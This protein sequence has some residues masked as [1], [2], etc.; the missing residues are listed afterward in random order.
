MSEQAAAAPSRPATWYQLDSEA[1]R[2]TAAERAVRGE[3]ARRRCRGIVMR[4][5]TRRRTGPTR[6]ACW[7][8]QA[9]SRVPELVPLQN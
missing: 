6:S 9:R 5:S 3:A 2:L 8:E 7:G 1:G 4:C